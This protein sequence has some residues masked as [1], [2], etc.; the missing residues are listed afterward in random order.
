MYAY[1]CQRNLHYGGGVLLALCFLNIRLGVPSGDSRES[2]SRDLLL[3]SIDADASYSYIAIV[4]PLIKRGVL[5]H[6]RFAAL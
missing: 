6:C 4:E 5:L 3:D 1:L 2:G